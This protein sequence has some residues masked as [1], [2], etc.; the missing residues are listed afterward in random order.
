MV[1]R[2]EAM[3]CL[4]WMPLK[5]KLPVDCWLRENEDRFGPIAREYGWQD[6]LRNR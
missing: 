1:K 2:N 3:G 6:E 5:A 4:C